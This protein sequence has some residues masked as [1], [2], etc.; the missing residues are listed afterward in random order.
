MKDFIHHVNIVI[1]VMCG[2]SET[3]I[4]DSQFEAEFH[5]QPQHCPAAWRRQ[6]AG[7]GT[8]AISGPQVNAAS[9]PPSSDTSPCASLPHAPRVSMATG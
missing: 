2:M 9:L 5:G 7:G 1:S 6:G 3:G 8:P 4:T